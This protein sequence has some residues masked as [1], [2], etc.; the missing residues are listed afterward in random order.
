MSQV[1]YDLNTIR[2]LEENQYIYAEVKT[3]P[4]PLNPYY[5]EGVRNPTFAFVEGENTGIVLMPVTDPSSD[6]LNSRSEPDPIFSRWNSTLSSV[7][8]NGGIALFHWD[9]S[10]IG[11]PDFTGLFSGFINNSTS[12]GVTIT[13]PD[14]IALHLKKLEVVQV[15]VISGDRYVILD[16]NN[17]E[18]R[19][20]LR[21]Y[22]YGNNAGY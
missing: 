6:N 7:R 17:S 22:L 18:G 14:A 12:N 2:S 1:R 13:T 19:R 9:L 15:H 10:D 16:A 4:A 11:N 21:H 3:V 8:Q 20:C 5:K